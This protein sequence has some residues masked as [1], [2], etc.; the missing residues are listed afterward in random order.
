MYRLR[1]STAPVRHC[2][3][4]GPHLLAY[5]L[6]VASS[7]MLPSQKLWQQNLNKSNAAQQDLINSIDPNIYDI[8]TLQEPYV[9]F[10]DNTRANQRWYPLLPSTHCNNLSK[11]C[12]ATFINKQILTSAWQQIM[13]NSQDIVLTAI[14]T[15]TGPITI[16]NIYNNRDHSNSLHTIR[17]TLVEDPNIP[18]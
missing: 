18:G 14:N 6:V 3:H 16:F 15:P 2:S 7:S 9:D 13:I 11:T 10:L 4:I 5:L 17:R 8:I 1:I 12:A